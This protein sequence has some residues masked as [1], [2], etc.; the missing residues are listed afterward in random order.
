[1]EKLGVPG[2]E[3]LQRILHDLTESLHQSYAKK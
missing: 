1:M 3:E 2:V